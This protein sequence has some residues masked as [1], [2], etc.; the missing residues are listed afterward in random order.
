MDADIILIEIDFRSRQF[1]NA[2][3]N[4]SHS[5]P[6]VSEIIGIAAVNGVSSNVVVYPS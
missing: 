2:W 1:C 4:E 5:R 3:N 6:W